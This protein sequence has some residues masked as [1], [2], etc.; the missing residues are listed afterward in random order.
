MRRGLQVM[1]AVLALASAHAADWVP[2]YRIRYPLRLAVDPGVSSNATI[3]ARLPTGGWVKPD[4]SDIIAQAGSG[5]LLPVAVLSHDPRGSTIVQF[6]RSG[7]ETSYWAYAVNPNPSPAGRPSAAVARA[8]EQARLANEAKMKAQKA[9]A[10]RAGEQRDAAEQRGRAQETAR[11]AAAEVA[12][13]DKLIPERLAVAQAAAAKTNEARAAVERAG[14]AAREAEAKAAGSQDLGVRMAAAKARTEREQAEQELARVFGA[15][16]AAAAAV[17]QAGSSRAAAEALRASSE[18]TAG[19]LAPRLAA[20]GAA[21]EAA[22]LAASQ[23]V[24]VAS[25]REAEYSALASANDP[26][27]RREGLTLE[28]REWAGDELSDWATVWVGLHRSENVLGNAIVP[29]VL[30]AGNPARRSD[31]RNFAASYRG[32]LRIERPGV[33]RFFANGDDASFVFI[34]GFKVYA[35]TGSNPPIR[36]R[37]PVLSVG[38]DIELE[39]GVHAIEV[40]S[41]VGNTPGASGLCSLLWLTPGAKEWATVPPSAFPSALPALVA[42]VEE[43]GGGGACVVEYGIDDTLSSDGVSLRLVRFAASGA[44]AGTGRLAWDF[45]DGTAGAGSSPMHVYFREGDFEVALRS[46]DALPPFRRRINVWTAPV[47]TSPLGLGRAVDALA[48]M[49]PARLDET[50][51]KSA[52]EFLLICEQTNRWPL[53]ERLSRSLLAR[54][55]QDPQFRM[56]LH[57]ALMDSLARQG[58]AG[59]ALKLFPKAAEEFA[60]LRSLRAS[61]TLAA[62]DIQRGSL[63]DYRAAD[64]LY[65]RVVDESRR[66]NHPAVRQALI[67]RGDMFLELGDRARAGQAYRQ[68]ESLGH[69]AGIGESQTDASTRG[70]LLRVAEQQLRKGDVTQSR[71]LLQRIERD[72]PEQKM[73]GLYRYL[74]AEADRTIGRYE[75][76]MRNYEVLLDLRQWA[77]YQP[78]AFHGLADCCYRLG[79]LTNALVWLDGLTNSYPEYYVERGLGPYQATIEARLVRVRAASTSATEAAAA[80]PFAGAE[81][82]FEMRGLGVFTNLDSVHRVSATGIR[83]PAAAAMNGWP[84]G[85]VSARVAADLRNVTS[86]GWLWLECWYRDTMLWGAP[87]NPQA[88]IELR[89]GAGGGGTSQT[90]YMEPTYGEWR[91]LGV[92]LKLPITQDARATFGFYNMQGLVELDGF[93]IQP[94]TDRQNEGLR[95]FIEGSTPP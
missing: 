84:K 50:R 27:A 10:D 6:N 72:Y 48:A 78:M 93:S 60:S 38:S 61:L 7:V 25:A 46:S 85:V 42:G 30:N 33:Y 32:F 95:T 20:L 41:V 40:H 66:Q 80:A 89:G 39:A 94:V 86:E 47:P 55:G 73:E 13:W 44:P 31:P 45:G 28:I 53:L 43:A 24:A 4:A 81:S 64:A 22:R 67:A 68:A 2:G 49:D 18:R 21:V 63:K 8:S 23:A 74:R 9:A 62:A 92:R 54:P 26:R 12:Q 11:K 58:K 19:E 88:Q 15:A 34:D 70:A 56:I 87:G 69:P 37:V 79:D 3:I 76:A 82:G 71:R 77:G 14:V 52:F 29:A 35:R 59:E 17:S 5:V 75:E 90:L 57:S 16:N 65:Q 91:K 51:Q 36:G 83:G 1:A